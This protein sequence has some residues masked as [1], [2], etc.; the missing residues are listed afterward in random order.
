MTQFASLEEINKD[1]G[2]NGQ[3]GR[4]KLAVLLYSCYFNRKVTQNGHPNVLMNATHPGFVSTKQSRQ[5]I[6]EPY[7]LGGYA[8]KYGLEPLKKDQFEGAVP[9]MFCVTKT[10]D[11]GQYI[12]PPCIPEEGSEMSQS[13][14]LADR[15]MELMRNIVVEKMKMDSVER[16][17]PMDDTVVH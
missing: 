13:D 1:V 15:L 14:E 5:D 2:P 11:F 17:C 3:Y 7:P 12:C 9:T 4:S 6:L 16:R 10:E 8:M